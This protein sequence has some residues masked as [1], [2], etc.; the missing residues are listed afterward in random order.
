[1]A[2][3]RIYVYFDKPLEPRALVAVD[4]F[5]RVYSR[6][7]VLSAGIARVD[8]VQFDTGPGPI[9]VGPDVV[10]YFGVIAKLRDE[11]GLEIAPWFNFPITLV[12]PPFP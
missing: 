2:V 7:R 1:M 6:V 5:V 11:D 10:T 4:W 3:R 9:N 8:R 12:P